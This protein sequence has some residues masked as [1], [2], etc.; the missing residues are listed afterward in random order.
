MSHILLRLNGQPLAQYPDTDLTITRTNPYFNDGTEVESYPFSVPIEGNR[1]VFQNA[2]VIESDAT[3]HPVRGGVMEVIVDGVPM[4]SG[5]CGS[6]ED[7]E[8]R[9]RVSLKLESAVKTLEEYLEGVRCRDVALKDDILIGETIGNIKIVYSGSIETVLMVERKGYNTNNRPF[10]KT[11][12]YILYT[13]NVSSDAGHDGG[14]TDINA[15]FDD[16]VERVSAPTVELPAL[17]F[18]RPDICKEKGGGSN[19]GEESSYDS[20]GNIDKEPTVVQSFANVSN[21]YPVTPF[22]TTRICYLHHKI[23]EDGTSSDDIEIKQ[24]DTSEYGKYN[25]YLVLE[26]NRPATGLCFYVLYFLDCLFACLAKDGVQYDNSEL[27]RVDDLCRLAFYTTHHKFRTEV[28]R[29]GSTY[30]RLNNIKQINSWLHTRNINTTLKIDDSVRKVEFDSINIDDHDYNVGDFVDPNVL[31]LTNDIF[32]KEMVSQ[33]IKSMYYQAKITT[34]TVTADIM[35]MYATSQNFPDADAKEIIDNLWGAFGIRFYLDPD[36]RIIKPRFIRDILRDQSSPVAFPCTVIDVVKQTEDIRGFR[37]LYGNTSDEQQRKDNITLGVRDYDTTYDYQDYS[38]LNAKLKYSQIL[39]QVHDSNMTCY[40]DLLTGN[41]FRIKIDGDVDYDDMKD[42][43]GNLSKRKNLHPVIFE[44]GQL[45]CVE[46][47]DCSKDNADYIIEVSNSFQPIVFNDVNYRRETR[48]FDRNTYVMNDGQATH[49][50]SMANDVETKQILT[51][52]FSEDMW[53]ENIKRRIYYPV[54]TETIQLSLIAEIT[55]KE[56][57]DVSST[58]DGDSPLQ[59]ADW[60]LAIAI[61]RGGGSDSHLDYYDYNYDGFGN[62]KYRTVAGTDYTMSLDSIDCYSQQYD[63]NGD[64]PGTDGGD[65]VYHGPH[66]TRYDG[67]YTKAEAATKITSIWANS[68]ADLLSPQRKLT[69]K[70][71]L[72]VGWE[73][74]RGADF[75]TVISQTVCL[76]DYDG[77]KREFLVTPITD[78]G[79]IF[80]PTMFTRYLEGLEKNAASSHRSIMT[81]DAMA[82]YGGECVII[83][84]FDDVSEANKYHSPWADFYSEILHQFHAIYYGDAA[85]GEVRCPQPYVAEHFSLKLRAYIP[86]PYDILGPD[87]KLIPA[88]EPLCTATPEVRNRGLFDTFFSEYAHWLLHRKKVKLTIHCEVAALLGI[89]WHKRYRFGDYVGFI[90]KLTSHITAQ[91]GLEQVEVELFI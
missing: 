15:G 3:I 45:S 57:F 74:G 47:G 7:Q 39:T 30:E 63:Y 16:K 4:I 9:D 6:V 36:T 83:Q 52:F 27:V 78:N 89:Q 91:N 21:P 80:T 17:G 55:T 8:L 75:C 56:S 67:I 29:Q 82:I 2:E 26:A 44:V 59:H 33:Q 48:A 71:V 46:I 31:L 85:S 88:G 65:N 72:S 77:V 53:H 34:P 23:A 51:P 32:F 38:N 35:N 81:L 87:G 68:N 58:D 24:S 10:V 11:E 49:V 62:C 13:E 1:Q 5:K 20:D 37:M 28:R 42:S 22:C 69:G 73:A 86:A 61:M 25:P 19:Y 79:N 41:R 90:N 64:L 43:N 54:G 84:Q 70:L 66:D 60:G 40:V 12:P 50:V 76:T 18:S 14:L